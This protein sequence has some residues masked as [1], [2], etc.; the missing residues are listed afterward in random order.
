MTHSNAAACFPLDTDVHRSE[1]PARVEKP[2]KRFSLG[3]AVKIG[4]APAITGR[5]S[6]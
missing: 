2:P 3:S 4:R 5:V 1:T 6:E